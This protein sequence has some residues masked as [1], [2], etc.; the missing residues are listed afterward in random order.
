MQ[1]AASDEDGSNTMSNLRSRETWRMPHLRNSEP[2]R[3]GD[4]HQDARNP[5]PGGSADA[6]AW[7]ERRRPSGAT[8]GVTF[9]KPAV[10]CQL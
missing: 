4:L 1:R 2:R 5:R 7:P 8:R 6:G 10:G 9:A 3:A